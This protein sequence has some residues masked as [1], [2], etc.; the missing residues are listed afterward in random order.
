MH[1]AEVV[2]SKVNAVRRPQVFPLLREG[3]CQSREAAHLHSDRQV[4]AL[5]NAGANAGRV[6]IAEYWDHLR[7]Q[8]ED[9]PSGCTL[10]P[11]RIDGLETNRLNGISVSQKFG[12]GGEIRTL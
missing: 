5:N 2:V 8:N 7:I 1:S 10:R 12:K 4:L 9:G 6:G 3:V 11:E